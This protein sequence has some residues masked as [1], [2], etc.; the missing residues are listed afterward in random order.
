MRQHFI[1]AVFAMILGILVYNQVFILLPL[2]AFFYVRFPKR[3]PLFFLLFAGSFMWIRWANLPPSLPDLPSEST[4][5]HAHV[6]RI[7]RRTD[8][9]QT[10]IVAIN[11]HQVFMSF[12]NPYPRLIPG[13]TIDVVGQLAIPTAPTVPHRFN[14]REFLRHQNIHFTLQTSDVI[15][16]DTRFSPWRF[17][18]DVA[19]W[20]RNTFPPLTAS[21]LQSF[22]LGLRDDLDEE[23]LSIYGDLGILH[24][25]AISGVHVTLLTGIVRD[26]LKRIGLIDLIVDGVLI[27]F[28]MAFIFLTGG[29]ISIIRAS[30]MAILA[31]INRRLKLGFSTFDLF[32]I[33]FM[34]SFIL[35]PLV[36]YQRGFQFSY[37]ISFV[38]ICSRSS[39]RQLTPIGNRLAI[40]FL[41]RMASIPIALSSSYEINLTSYVANLILVPLL[42]QLIIP[43]L[44][45]TL[46]LPFLNPFTDFLLQIFEALN[47]FLHP[48]LHLNIIFGSIGLSVIVLLMI[49]LLVSCYFY[50]KEKKW[51]IRLVLI[52]LY[53]IILEANRVW[54]PYSTLTFLDV[55]Q[56]DATIVRSPHH[57]CV[58]VFDTGGEVR[59][60]RWTN[61]SI[62]HQTLEPYLLG[63]GVRHIDY[64]ILSHES[65]DHIAEAIP[66]MRRFRVR[67]LIISGADIVPRLQT[68]ID[69]AN[70]QNIP[71]HTAGA[72][73]QLSCGNQQYHFLQT[74]LHNVNPNDENL[75]LTVNI[76]GLTAFIAVD[77]SSQADHEILAQFPY[78]Q[79][80]IF[81]VGHHGSRNSNSHFFTSTIN[82]TYAVVSVGRI[83][84]YG[85]PS[86]ELFDVMEGLNIPLLS[87]ATHGTIQ[88]KHQNG[89]YQ[90]YIWPLD[91][92]LK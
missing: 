69:E 29:S 57:D 39:L 86:Q 15:I 25:F 16:T 89:D 90:I 20:M 66:L 53:L 76:D 3:Y 42:M 43:A 83:N 75:T 71:V 79:I 49:L 50:E 13:Q 32:S 24:V 18:Y 48:F 59:R 41:A 7:R 65:Y 82:P 55:G 31:L 33:V 9:L 44:L 51:W 85:H 4:T 84:S 60:L 70:S 62:F 61:P 91:P 72:G 88:F 17:Q 68:I 6:L 92:S 56:G 47:G 19:T 38:L 22:F 37:W 64:L 73:D 74:D 36:V 14:F 81:R 78:E 40:V 58:I 34:L 10:A 1:Y 63:A 77:L 2:L 87:T 8:Q 30:S 46:F 52:G 23:V 5:H 28:C 54:Q 80:D 26:V 11:G 35:N 45:L 67:N 21:Y 27:L 12:R